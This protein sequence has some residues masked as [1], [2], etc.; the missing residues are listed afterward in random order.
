MDSGWWVYGKENIQIGYKRSCGEWSIGIPVF[1]RYSYNLSNFTSKKPTEMIVYGTNEIYVYNSSG[2]NQ[3]NY[4]SIIGEGYLFNLGSGYD[5][6]GIEWMTGNTC[7]GFNI[8]V[9]LYNLSGDLLTKDQTN[10]SEIYSF[11]TTSF[12]KIDEIKVGTKLN[13][14][15]AE[16]RSSSGSYRKELLQSIVY[17][18]GTV[19]NQT[20]NT[21]STT[22]VLD[23]FTNPNPDELV[24]RV[25]YWAREVQ[26]SGTGYVRNRKVSPLLGER[27]FSVTFPV[28]KDV[29]NFSIYANDTFGNLASEEFEWDYKVV[30]NEIKYDKTI[31]ESEKHTIIGNFTINPQPK[32]ITLHYNGEV[33]IPNVTSQ[34][35]SVYIASVSPLAPIV[36]ETRNITNYFEFEIGSEKFN[37]TEF[38]QT[39]IDVELSTNCAGKFNV[40][41]LT[42]Y[43][44]ETLALMSAKNEYI[45][46]LIDGSGNTISKLSGNFTGQTISL[47]SNINISELSSYYNLQVRY[48]AD[49]FTYKT[50]NIESTR[51]TN[52]P[53]SIPLY[54]LSENRS[55]LFEINY[56]DWKYFEHPGA[57]LQIQRQYLEED[58]YRTVEI[59]LIDSEGNSKASFDTRNIKYKLVAV[60]NGKILDI[61]NNVFP[62]CQS[63]LYEVCQMDLRGSQEPETFLS[64]DFIYRIESDNDGYIL[65]YSIPSGKPAS[66]SFETEQESVFIDSIS[67]CSKTIFGSSGTIR[68]GINKTVGD[69]VVDIKV[70]KNDELMAYGSS[71]KAQEAQE[72]FFTNNF[73]LAFILLLTLILMFV[74]NAVMM[75]IS[76]VVGIFYLALVMLITSDSINILTGA[77]SLAWL[78]LAAIILIYRISKKED[79]T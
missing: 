27:E 50:Y 24:D 9:D 44:E 63:D 37:S 55:F 56:K 78:L 75:V 25:E 62:Q 66:V 23:V 13:Y 30:E 74:G 8:S 46:N 19:V 40:L 11:T 5:D 69:S 35:N 71:R 39:I 47:C 43:N 34:D 16:I 10:P 45:L 73:F 49:N 36:D 26:T 33:I 7:S 57:I 53:I 2:K 12:V 38:F 14:T 65:T 61:F 76:S 79:K 20:K 48:Y 15:S 77:T 51:T 67:N 28:E 31:F 6:I 58:A 29:Y 70:K 64:E 32:S 22:Y 52:L 21:A 60:E 4:S 18:N 72:L 17:M 3:I 42:N 54:H 1:S 41:N 59:P 68:C